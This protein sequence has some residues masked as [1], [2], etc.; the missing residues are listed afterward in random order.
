MNEKT[1]RISVLGMLSALAVISVLLIR[2]PL[3]PAAPFLTYDPK[4]VI[5][6]IGGFIY[7]PLAALIIAVVAS[8][9]E[10]ITVSDTGPIGFVMNIISSGAF[11]CTA[12]IIY[13]QNRTLKGAVAGL[14]AAWI[15]TTIAMVLW[16][17]LIVPLYMEVPRHVV[18]GMLLPIF[19]PFNLLKGGL[20]AGFAMLLY[21]PVKSA[22]RAAN[23]IPPSPAKDGGAINIG[24]VIGSVLVIL[25]CVLF[26]MVMV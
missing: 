10:M 13:K 17:Y 21:K 5:I 14:M 9:V 8:F 24:V 18:A 2:V 20:N 25:A 4:D 6:V 19:V 12:A 26:V 1:K 22:I 3:M 11:A 7:G 16:N 23:L 15:V